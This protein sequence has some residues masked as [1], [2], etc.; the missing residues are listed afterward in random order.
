MAESFKVL[1]HFLRHILIAAVLFYGD[2]KG[3]LYSYGMQ[4]W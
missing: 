3:L 1:F 4:P 2:Y